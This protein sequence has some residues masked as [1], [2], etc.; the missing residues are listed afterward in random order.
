MSRLLD[1]GATYGWDHRD[2]WQSERDNRGRTDSWAAR[3]RR[4]LGYSQVRVADAPDA[5]PQWTACPDCG[6]SGY[7]PPPTTTV[8]PITHGEAVAPLRQ[9]AR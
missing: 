6:G 3:C 9:V 2:A 5:A 1:S 7:A 8:P 4:C